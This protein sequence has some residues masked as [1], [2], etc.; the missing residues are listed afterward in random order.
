MYVM[1]IEAGE[2]YVGTVTGD[3]EAATKKIFLDK[4]REVL[5][6]SAFKVTD[7]PGYLSLSC[8]NFRHGWEIGRHLG[9][10]FDIHG[11]PPWD[12][13]LSEIKYKPGI[14]ITNSYSD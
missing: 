10:L 13:T 6:D 5:V 14:D 7:K 9:C 1:K 11:D 3:D 12:Y 8:I 4:I 2:T